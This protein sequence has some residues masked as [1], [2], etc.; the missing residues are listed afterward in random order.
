MHEGGDVLGEDDAGIV[1]R[2]FPKEL[3][4]EPNDGA[5]LGFDRVERRLPGLIA[6]HHSLISCE[7]EFDLDQP[8]GW[9]ERD[10]MHG[11]APARRK[12]LEEHGDHPL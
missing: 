2:G 8:R 10:D 1:D 3:G 7:N 9:R 4:E 5:K 6:D 11:L 12:I